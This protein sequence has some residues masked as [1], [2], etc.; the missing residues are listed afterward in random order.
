MKPKLT[1]IALSCLCA[2]A[3]AQEA[4]PPAP[5]QAVVR[6]PHQRVFP[7]T[8]EVNMASLDE[9]LQVTIRG[10]FVKGAAIHVTM[11]GSGPKFAAKLPDPDVNLEI[12]VSKNGE[13]YSLIYSIGTQSFTQ[14]NGASRGSSLS[15][16]VFV[17]LGKPVNVISIGEQQLAITLSKARTEKE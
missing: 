16:N 13:K 4:Q 2:I 3:A 5:S 7:Q 14:P 8:S 12:L 6:A 11:V 1:A 17:E 10:S 15:G 9:N